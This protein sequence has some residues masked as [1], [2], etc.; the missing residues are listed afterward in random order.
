M[1]GSTFASKFMIGLESRPE[2][3]L[4]KNSK[5]S[6]LGY[7]M[8]DK[9]GTLRNVNLVRNSENDL[10]KQTRIETRIYYRMFFIARKNKF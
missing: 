4:C 1:I 8:N 5:K 9:I 7:K 3:K 10:E 6:P 2:K